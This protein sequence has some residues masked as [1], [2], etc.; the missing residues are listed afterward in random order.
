MRIAYVCSDY[1][2]PVFGSKGAS[3]HVRALSQA[4]HAA[5]HDVLIVAARGGG[6]RPAGFRVPVYE[7]ALAPLEATTCE[8]LHD[9]VRG[10]RA[11]ARDVRASLL[12]S[13]LHHRAAAVLR[14]FDPDLVYERHSL[15]GTAGV[16]LAD[17]LAVPLVLEVNAPLAEEH[18]G[19]RGLAFDETARALERRIL[20][21]ADRVIAVSRELERW[22]VSE[23]GVDA[24]RVAVLPN[25]VDVARFERGEVERDETRAEL[26]VTRRPVV[27]FVGT[28]KP[29]HGTATLVAA[30]A[31]LHRAGLEPQLVVVGDGPERPALEKLARDEGI[32]GF[33]TFVGN[34]PHERVPAHVAAFDVAVAPYDESER[35]YFSPLKLFEYL[36]AARPVVAADVGDIG[37]C[38]RPGRTGVLYPAGDE[39]ALAEAIHSLL[40]DPA[41]AARLGAAGREHVRAQHGWEG[42]ARAVVSLVAHELPA[43]E[44]AR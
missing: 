13:V 26:G 32:G 25:A 27:G 12:A 39:G 7:V 28:L 3:V 30:V 43:V 9:D 35:F 24:G 37:H 20:R 18:A 11:V 23:V 14:D 15:L 8:L 31:R 41:R 5:G 10:G 44:V 2:I 42:S 29:W 36:A 33:A 34:V 17:E 6:P 19:H 16:S 4:L 38:V 21:S 40:A 22:L 1:G